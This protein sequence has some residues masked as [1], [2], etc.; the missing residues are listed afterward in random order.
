MYYFK[1]LL[2][3][4]VSFKITTVLSQDVHIEVNGDYAIIGNDYLDVKFD[5]T[6]GQYSCIDKKINQ[7]MIKDAWF[8]LDAGE[9]PWRNPKHQYRA[10]SMGIIEDNLGIG[11]KIRVWYLPE[12]SYDPE[13]FLDLTVYRNKKFVVFGWGVKNPFEYRIRVRNAEILQQGSL[14]DN[15]ILNM[16]KVLRSGAG[17]QANFVEDTWQVDAYN[18]AMVTYKDASRKNERRTLVGGGLKYDEFAKSFETHRGEIRENLGLGKKNYSG[19]EPYLTLSIWDPQGKEVL[20]GETWESKDTYYLDFVTQSPFE[21]L[22]TYGANL[23]LANKA[24][25][26]AYNFP[27]LCGWIVSTKNLGEGKNINH[28]AALV[29]Q[30]RKAKTSGILKYTPVTVRLE[31]DY[32]CYGNQGNTQQGWWDDAYWSKYNALSK[33]Y[34]T[35]KKFSKAVKEFG[36][37]VFTYFQVSL[38]SNDFAKEHPDWMINNDISLL[39]VDHPHHRPLV[40]YDY[41]NTA[42]QNYLLKMWKKLA[43]DGVMGIKF[44]YPETGWERDGGFDDKSYT[45]TSA[46]RKIY[47]LCREGMGSDA[48]IHERNLGETNTPLLDCTVGIV[49][50]Q[51]VWWDASH[52]EPEMASRIGLRWFKQGKA[53]RY[54]PDGKSFYFKGEELSSIERRAFLSLVGLL[55]GRLELGTSF[56]SMT[57]DMQYDLSRIYPVLPNGQ[58]FR[59]IDMFM[60]KKH[61]EVYAYDVDKDWKQV[62][63]VNNDVEKSKHLIAPLSG[64]QVETGALGLEESS[65]YHVFDFWN[66]TYLGIYKGDASFSVNF[67]PKEANVFAFHKVK[68]HPQI[69]GTNRHIMCGMMELDDVTWD[70][71]NRTLSFEVKL[72]REET[73]RIFIAVPKNKKEVVKKVNASN[74]KANV[75]YNDSMIVLE[76]KPNTFVNGTDIITVQFEN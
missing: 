4:V 65:I 8:R 17:A 24:A 25:P 23:A 14:F 68:S 5:L 39:H 2:V 31:P 61:P 33:P 27:T 59:P 26:K 71:D 35:F 10:E 37:G 7:A 13:R 49:D 12:E 3:L 66:Q 62:L 50:L 46:Y 45:T 76:L 20:P 75:I 34:E 1:Y 74:V 48:F 9:V 70:N 30:M 53:F 41:T 60:G 63:F 69:I 67:Q 51:R 22:E 56:G 28:S 16:P 6:T 36:G 43:N 64:N 57:P 38:P 15:Q 21:S 47:E 52:F 32:Y 55:S 42:F 19:N 54:Y 44:D 29:E 72:V 11:K 58:S 18:G 40:R 73:M